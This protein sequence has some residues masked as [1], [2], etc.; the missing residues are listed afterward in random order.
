M[1]LTSDEL[2]LL[3]AIVSD[4]K[5]FGVVFDK[6]K[7]EESEERANSAR[8]GL[9][10]KGVLKEDGIT[11]YG[12]VFMM[13]WEKY[14]QCRN[15]VVINRCIIAVLEDRRCMA[16]TRIDE[17]FE[18]SSGDAAFIILACLKEYEAFRRADKEDLDETKTE[19]DYDTFRKVSKSYGENI[20]SVGIF[21]NGI[22]D[23]KEHIF[24]WDESKIMCF[25]P[26]KHETGEVN[27]SYIRIMIASALGISLED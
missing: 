19:M 17:G 26:M 8:A 16:I 21:T 4:T 27:S 25:D 7:T 3:S 14:I 15:F 1:L 13:L 2:Y 11:E 24:F 5:P 12:A 9:I 10:K 23:A 18:I 22:K 6:I 20:V